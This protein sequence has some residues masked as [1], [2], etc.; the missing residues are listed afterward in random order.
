VGK[1][2]HFPRG[3]C[4]VKNQEQLNKVKYDSV[5]YHAGDGDEIVV[6]SS[7]N[8]NE[9]IKRIINDVDP[10]SCNSSLA[11]E[12]RKSVTSKKKK[13]KESVNMDKKPSSKRKKERNDCDKGVHATQVTRKGK[14]ERTNDARGC[15]EET[16]NSKGRPTKAQSV[17]KS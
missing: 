9:D 8:E 10:S 1:V 14:K 11:C 16:V 13:K 3:A 6:R 12:S 4:G 5:I 15:N 7:S 17:K 2:K